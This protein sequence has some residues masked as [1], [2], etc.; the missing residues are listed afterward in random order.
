M[1]KR[2]QEFTL[3]GR[4]PALNEIIS[5]N[6]ENR[7]SGARQKARAGEMVRM[8]IRKE[9]LTRMQ[10]PVRITARFYERDRRRDPDGIFSGGW[11]I[12]L[13][14]LQQEGII[15]NDNQRWLPGPMPLIPELY[16][17]AKNPRIEV[18]LEEVRTDG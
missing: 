1:I 13:D 6:R 9:A 8:E 12:I 17:D 11:K 3:E 2:R 10:P 14:A 16:I 4:L 15:G 18:T 7:F 5:A